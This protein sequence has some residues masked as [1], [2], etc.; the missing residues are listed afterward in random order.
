MK[1]L[2]FIL[3]FAGCASSKPPMNE[4]E[5]E[6]FKQMFSEAAAEHG[7]Y[8]QVGIVIGFGDMPKVGT[9]GYCQ[10]YSNSNKFIVID[11]KA[12][13]GF[14][15]YQKEVLIF[16]EL[17]HC[18]LNKEHDN[19]GEEDYCPNSIMYWRVL[20]SYCYKTYRKEYLD[21]AFSD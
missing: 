5:F 19:S 1:Y 21:N 14:D 17:L 3:L 6:P 7:K 13:V 18:A 10:K 15:K 8:I 12:W 20:P 4:E 9:V 16:H 11:K 2:V